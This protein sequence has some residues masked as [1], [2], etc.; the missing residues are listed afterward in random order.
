MTA[1][2]TSGMLVSALIR[3]TQEEGGHA[4]V[5]VK[6]DATAGAIVILLAEKGRN[7]GLF[8]RSL[9]GKGA[10]HWARVGPQDID[11]VEEFDHYIQRRRRFDPDL[12][13]IELDVP[14]GERLIAQMMD[15]D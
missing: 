11:N 10:Y 14:Y 9:T 8:E 12:W 13:L 6:G 7:S 3:K 15:D 1:R 5:V 2:L 4:V